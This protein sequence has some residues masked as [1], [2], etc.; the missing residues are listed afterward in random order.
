LKYKTQELS[1]NCAFVRT[2]TTGVTANSKC[3]LFYV[4]VMEQKIWLTSLL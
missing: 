2:P 3:T 1:C 4:E